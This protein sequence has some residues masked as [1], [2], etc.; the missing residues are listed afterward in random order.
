MISEGYAHEY[1]YNLP[2]K[3]QS[4]FKQAEKDAREAG[5]GLWSASTC[6][7]ATTSVS[8]ATAST[9]Q[10]TTNCVIKGN[11]SADGE[12]I[13]HMPGQRYYDKTQIDATKG[14]RWFCSESEARAAGWR[15]SQ[16]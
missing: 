11:I 10:T 8:T 13:Y 2:Y 1:T 16:R 5:K 14:E 9:T 12:K 7:G 15:K 3:Y 6:N 4:E